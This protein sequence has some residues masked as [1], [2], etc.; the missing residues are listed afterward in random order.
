MSIDPVRA[1]FEWEG[2]RIELS[3]TVNWLNTGYDHVE[4]RAKE[5]LPL[6]K[7]GYRSH[8]IHAEELALFD[9]PVDF[10]RQWLDRMA[11]EPTW[12]QYLVDRQQLSLF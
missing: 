5:R 1:V 6:T 8:F 4:L 7:T 11:R 12:Q 3:H 2:I 9:G 10:A